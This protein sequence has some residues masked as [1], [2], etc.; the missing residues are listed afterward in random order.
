MP[1]YRCNS[2]GFIAEV[3]H[4]IE[5]TTH[6][7]KC[8]KPVTVYG[9][10]FF[11][12]QILQR[13]SSALQ[14]IKTLKA[15]SP[16]IAAPTPQAETNKSIANNWASLHTATQHAPLLS[17]FRSQNIQAELN[18]GNV[19]MS[20]Y[21]DEAARQISDNQELLTDVLGR[22]GWH[23]RKSYTNLNIELAQMTQKDAVALNRICKDWHQGALFAKYFYQKNEKIIRLGLQSATPARQFFEGA[24]LE[25]LALDSMLETITS[26]GKKPLS[27]A[28]GVKITFPNEDLQELDVVGLIGQ[29]MVCIECKTGEF[30]SDIEKL[31]RLKK[32]LNLP[33]EQFIICAAQLDT[34]QANALSAMYGMR[35]LNIPM[36]KPHLQQIGQYL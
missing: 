34:E 16:S 9:T 18:Y 2:C 27:F 33:Q 29:S 10:V 15:A 31:A 36:L 20:G 32:R 1:I 12:E 26:N 11:V 17:W 24:W 22:I 3:T 23:Y 5:Q 21:F 8:T 19:N 35:F 7:G 25:W 28:R 13:Y 30:R 14:E 6:C 4:Q